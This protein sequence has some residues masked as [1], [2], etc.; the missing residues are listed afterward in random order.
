MEKCYKVA[1]TYCN[2]RTPLWNETPYGY[3]K[4]QTLYLCH[5][6]YTLQMKKRITM[7]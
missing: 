6:S 3:V 7:N 2:F 4:V 1:N 5:I